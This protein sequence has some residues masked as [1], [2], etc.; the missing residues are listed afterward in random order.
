MQDTDQVL[1][2]VYDS[3]HSLIRR[4]NA[5]IYD[6][7]TTVASQDQ[8]KNVDKGQFLEA[9]RT[10][11]N[12]PL[13]RK[14]LEAVIFHCMCLSFGTDRMTNATQ[15]HSGRPHPGLSVG[16]RLRCPFI[17]LRTYPLCTTIQAQSEASPQR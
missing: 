2:W 6:H 12:S 4:T 14:A 7:N 17:A 11:A 13:D 16:V 10:A 9:M 3:I 15:V 8:F 1:D 5:S